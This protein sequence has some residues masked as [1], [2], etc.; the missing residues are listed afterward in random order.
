MARAA[1]TLA[2][3]SAKRR[4]MVIWRGMAVVLL[5]LI[6]ERRGTGFAGPQ[7]LPPARGCA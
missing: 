5:E 1:K 4:L 2:A 6:V 7:A 3:V